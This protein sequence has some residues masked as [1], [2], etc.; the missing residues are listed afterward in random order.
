MTSVIAFLILMKNEIIPGQEKGAESNTEATRT[1][2]SEKQAQDFFKIL[3]QRLSSVN[4]WQ[5]YAGKLTAQFRLIDANGNKADREVLKGDHFRIDIP[6]P[7]PVT[8]EGY[9]WVQVEEII[10]ESNGGS[11]TLAIRVRP[12]TNPNN[13]RNDVA[14]FFSDDATSSFVVSRE[15]VVVK[16]AVYGR[17]EKPNTHAE[18]VI[19]KARN[20]A[21]A[22]GA[23]AGAAKL[24]WK[25][26]VEG[27]LK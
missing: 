23:I 7:G 15:G 26:L 19:D 20:A 8:G 18:T 6:G 13:E 3:K 22:S 27:L 24:Q 12:A 17:N 11:E 9:D 2:A 5:H 21:V 1:F 25:S 14:H 4:Q 10:E 16:A